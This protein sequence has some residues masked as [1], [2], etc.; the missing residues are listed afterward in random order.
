METRLSALVSR[1][2]HRAAWF[3]AWVAASGRPRCWVQVE[4]MSLYPTIAKVLLRSLE[5]SKWDETGHMMTPEA[6][7][8]QPKTHPRGRPLKPKSCTSRSQKIF[9][10]HFLTP[11]SNPQ[12]PN[13]EPSWRW[14]VQRTS[15]HG[16]HRDGLCQ[17]GVAGKPGAQ[18]VSSSLSLRTS[19]C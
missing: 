10:H 4:V 11:H 3:G 6:L 1:T 17:R 16:Q 7:Q 9:S 5:V 19:T 8:P 12:N 14:G 18:D 13:H 2:I 15:C